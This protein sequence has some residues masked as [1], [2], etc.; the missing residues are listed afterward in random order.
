MKYEAKVTRVKKGVTLKCVFLNVN[1]SYIVY[2]YFNVKRRPF[3]S[4][5]VQ[6]A[7]FETVRYEVRASFALHGESPYEPVMISGK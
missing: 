2:F 6:L 7:G 5:K 4:G 1:C 3:C